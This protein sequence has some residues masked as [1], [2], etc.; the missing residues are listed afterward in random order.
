MLW[1][2]EWRESS[3]FSG[4]LGSTVSGPEVISD[5][6]FESPN[7]QIGE[8]GSPTSRSI[9]VYLMAELVPLSA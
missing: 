2:V 9:F 3:G 7:N 6:G 5:S 4:W 8:A 1:R